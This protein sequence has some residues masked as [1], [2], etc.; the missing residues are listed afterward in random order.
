MSRSWLQI[1][2]APIV[3]GH[4]GARHAHPENTLRAFQAALDEGAVGTEFDVMLSSD[5]RPVVFHDFDLRRMTEGRDARRVHRMTALELDAIKLSGDETIPRLEAVLDW[6]VRHD[7]LLNIELKSERPL[8][9]PVADVVAALLERYAEAPDFALVSSFHPTLVRRVA[10]RLPH[11]TCALLVDKNHPCLVHKAWLGAC[12][13]RAVHPHAG[14]LL[15]NPRIVDRV[16]GTLINTWTV[17]SEQQALALRGLP[18]TGIITDRPAAILAALAS[19][20]D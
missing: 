1:P 19:G 18:V 17:N 3:L 4:R 13:A 10:Q 7:A 20:V 14:L 15:D 5:K 6:A 9:D 8:F 2:S 16:A 12:G 11:V